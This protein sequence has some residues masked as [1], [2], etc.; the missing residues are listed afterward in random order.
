MPDPQE[1]DKVA[2]LKN[3][4][5]RRPEAEAQLVQRALQG[6]EFTA[7]KVTFTPSDIQAAISQIRTNVLLQPTPSTA[8]SSTDP[9][10]HVQAGAHD[11]SSSSVLAADDGGHPPTQVDGQEDEYSDMPALV[12]I[13]AEPD[14]P[15]K[16]Q[17][18][19]DSLK[20]NLMVGLFCHMVR[21]LLPYGWVSFAVWL[22][23]FCQVTCLFCRMV[24]SLFK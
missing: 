12:Y 2:V 19:L 17:D 13:D 15:K 20:R 18:T 5:S 23:R 24:R 6:I 10:A 14:K 22:G 1:V 3:I 4:I 8:S 21:S 7:G 11:Q 16:R 9:P